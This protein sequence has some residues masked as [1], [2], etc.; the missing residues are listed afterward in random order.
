MKNHPWLRPLAAA[1]LALLVLG[2]VLPPEAFSGRTNPILDNTIDPSEPG[3]RFDLWVTIT[4]RVSGTVAEGHGRIV[5][6]GEFQHW[7]VLAVT[8]GRRSF[9]PG[10]ARAAALAVSDQTQATGDA[11]QWLVDITL[12]E[13]E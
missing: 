1:S 3:A 11:H 7:E 8:V 13:E 4:Q 2:V 5:C 12:V 10:P 9:T 6:T